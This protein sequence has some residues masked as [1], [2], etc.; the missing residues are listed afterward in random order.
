[1]LKAARRRRSERAAGVIADVIHVDLDVPDA[2]ML[3]NFYRRLP[4]VTSV[5]GRSRASPVP[6]RMRMR[7]HER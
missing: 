4:V 3:A 7:M 2:A 5:D 1:M 6:P